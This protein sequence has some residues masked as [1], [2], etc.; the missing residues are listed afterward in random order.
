MDKTALHYILG[1]LCIIPDWIVAYVFAKHC[2]GPYMLTRIPVW[3]CNILYILQAE[4]IIIIWKV[5]QTSKVKIVHPYFLS[6]NSVQENAFQFL[7]W[8][9]IRHLQPQLCAPLILW[10][11]ETTTHTVC[12]LLCTQLTLL[13]CRLCYAS[14]LQHLRI[15]WPR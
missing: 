5:W 4:V 15:C 7:M 1:V 12:L 13:L 2:L 11:T 10:Y 3:P 14:L 9:E 6:T 8:F